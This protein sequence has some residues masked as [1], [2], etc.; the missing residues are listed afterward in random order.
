MTNRFSSSNW[1]VPGHIT[2]LFEIV[3]SNNPLQMGSRGAGFSI[4][5]PIFTT[6]SYEKNDEPG[7]EIFYNN[8][9]I[10]GDVDL[11]VTKNFGDFCQDKHLV[12]THFSK[13]PIG[14]GFGTSGAGALGTA[15]AL[16]EIC[17]TNYSKEKLGQIAH[18][19]E[20]ICHTGLGDV[21]SQLQ[22]GAEI[23]TEAGAPG[24]GSIKDFI[25]PSKMLV[26]SANLGE[27]STKA[28]ITNTKYV[29]KINDISQDLL[30]KLRLKP[31]LGTFLDVSYEFAQKI[32]LMS[33]EV[34]SLLQEL[35]KRD[36]NGSMI[37][38]GKSIFVVGKKNELEKCSKYLKEHYPEI[39]C[40]INNLASTGPKKVKK[41]KL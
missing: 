18:Q 13:L 19:A 9:K 36:Y 28:I 31:I 37:M 26:L 20:V 27:L 32:G 25:W 10:T 16:N 22:G 40:W 3:L 33:S 34:S 12:I 39:N 17:K 2:G 7:I 5:N 8:E 21:I 4:D 1:A 14:A 41:V 38:L 24:Y 11:E 15:F 35:H 6:V 29:Y 30:S 23:R